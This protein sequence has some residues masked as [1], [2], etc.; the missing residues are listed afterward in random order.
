VEVKIHAFLNSA[1][2]GVEWLALRP[3]SFTHKERAPGT[4]WIGSWVGPRADLDVVVKRKIPNP[5]RDSNPRSSSP[6]RS[7]ISLRYPGS[8][9]KGS[10]LLTSLWTGIQN[11][12]RQNPRNHFAIGVLPAIKCSSFHPA[13]SVSTKSTLQ[14][15]L[16]IAQNSRLGSFAA[17]ECT[18]ISTAIIM[19]FMTYCLFSNLLRILYTHTASKLISTLEITSPS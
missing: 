5:C 12:N 6:Q 1:L 11:V 19:I 9:M 13:P 10:V 16:L 2:D 7:A 4:H 17:L 18:Y 14:Q 8:L 3:S 15:S